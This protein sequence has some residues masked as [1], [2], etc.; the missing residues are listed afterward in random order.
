MEPL[1]SENVL[2]GGGPEELACAPPRV[3]RSSANACCFFFGAADDQSGVEH[4]DFFGTLVRILGK[5]F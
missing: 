3:F 5:R 1:G 4:L 2:K